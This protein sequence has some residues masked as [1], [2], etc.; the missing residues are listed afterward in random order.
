MEEG[1][2]LLA[3]IDN[4]YTVRLNFPNV[5]DIEGL[6]DAVVALGHAL[7]DITALREEMRDQIRYIMNLNRQ[8]GTGV[9]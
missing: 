4:L 6:N 5:D 2:D 1:R 9:G 8:Q 7:M 3:I